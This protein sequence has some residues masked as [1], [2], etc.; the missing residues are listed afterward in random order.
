[1]SF[2]SG[3]QICIYSDFNIYCL[4]FFL[5]EKN[6]ES[7]NSIFSMGVWHDKARVLFHL[8]KDK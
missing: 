7:L 6:L 4:L 1:M 8:S 3:I 2:I 5:L